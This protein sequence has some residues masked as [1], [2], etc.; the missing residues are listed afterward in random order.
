VLGLWSAVIWLS[1]PTAVST[2]HDDRKLD[3]RGIVA[4][5]NL[6]LTKE[7]FFRCRLVVRAGWA[8]G[9]RVIAMP[10]N[11]VHSFLSVDFPK[12]S[13]YLLLNGQRRRPWRWRNNDATAFPSPLNWQ[14][15]NW[16]IAGRKEGGTAQPRLK[17][18]YTMP[19][20]GATSYVTVKNWQ[21][22]P[23]LTASS[24]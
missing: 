20:T 3:G 4:T 17:G 1:K 22:V 16:R 21:S 24:Y 5:V 7:R 15:A 18:K 19:A 13:S 12:L 9:C 10:R 14:I 6:R 11:S 8:Y 2:W 23:S